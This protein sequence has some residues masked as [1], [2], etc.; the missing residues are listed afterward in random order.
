M[1]VFISS[2]VGGFEAF[3]NAARRAIENI[4][5]TPVMCEDFGARPYSSERACLTEIEGSEV[6]VLL[7][8]ER[9]GFEAGQGMSVTQQEFR[10]AKQLSLP[11][12]VFIH[13]VEMEARQ[14][15]FR[16]EVEAYHSGFCRE[17]FSNA[18]QLKDAIVRQLVL[19]GRT[20]DAMP[21]AQFVRR[22]ADAQ[23]SSWRGNS[24]DV[25]FRFAFLPQPL[26]DLDLRQLEV[27][28]D[29]TFTELSAL[30]LATL[31]F[32]YEPIDGP[33]HT[34]IKSGSVVLRQFDDGLVTYEAP[35]SAADSGHA[36]GHWYVPPS[37]VRRMVNACFKLI[38][39]NA[40][41]C[42]VGLAGMEN[43]VMKELPQE[44]RQSFSMP[45]MRSATSAGQSRL[46]VPCT[47]QAFEHWADRAVARFERE[48]GDT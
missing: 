28:R 45:T 15:E 33:D 42:H 29:A 10:H 22:I 39:A 30:G 12:L 23:G 35:V 25:T 7:L 31:R 1:R 32:G 27:R 4:A 21:E 2:V 13:D 19:L 40:G 41:W 44:S 37:R 34:G 26:R 6:F 46:L 48:F 18:E 20:R 24:Q 17:L 8:G 9:F 36:F 3:R 14:L 38:N 43:A 11:I 16:R 5:A 47:E